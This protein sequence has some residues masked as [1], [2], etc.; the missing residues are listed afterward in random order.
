MT[1]ELSDAQHG[2][3]LTYVAA[4]PGDIGQNILLCIEKWVNVEQAFGYPHPVQVCSNV[5]AMHSRQPIL[6]DQQCLDL[7]ILKMHLGQA[8]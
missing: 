6:T 7:Q 8:V 3:I 2:N 5:Q 1:T 4:L